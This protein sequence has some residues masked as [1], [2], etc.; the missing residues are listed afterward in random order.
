MG[1]RSRAARLSLGALPATALAATLNVNSTADEL[2]AGN[3]QCTLREAITNAN[4]DSDTTA[5]DCAARSGADLINV[6]SGTYTLT[7]PGA[8]ENAGATGDLD[9]RS[10][11]T[12]RGA[13]AAMTALV[14][15]TSDIMVEV[16]RGN[17]VIE[18]LRVTGPSTGVVNR[19]NLIV[20]DVIISNSPA[21]V[22][23]NGGDLLLRRSAVINNSVYGL[24]YYA[25]SDVRVEGSTISG[26]GLP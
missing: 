24:A 12:L 3:G 20:S 26:N 4:G 6:P 5:G 1:G 19:A 16:L 23:V 15:T 7:I 18:R 8:L 14:Q 11:L 21:G 9:V 17:V 13:G 25:E 10:D 22:V 2:I